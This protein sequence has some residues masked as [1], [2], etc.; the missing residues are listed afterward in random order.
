MRR[1]PPRSTRTDTLFPDTTLFRSAPGRLPAA[2][3]LGQVLGQRRAG[4]LDPAFLLLERHH[5]PE[6]P[7]G[8]DAVRLLGVLIDDQ[9]W[10]Y[11]ARGAHFG[12]VQRRGLLAAAAVDRVGRT[13]RGPPQAQSAERPTP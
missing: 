1:L 3:H 10:P 4:L 6:A 8:G 11:V 7:R 12:Q 9:F 2:V 13:Q 5:L